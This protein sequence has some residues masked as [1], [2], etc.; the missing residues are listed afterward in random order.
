MKY[1][2]LDEAVRGLYELTS[3][4]VEQL[5]ELLTQRC[6]PRTKYAVRLA[7]ENIQEQRTYGIYERVVKEPKTGR[8]QY[9]AGQSYPE[10]IRTVR[11]LLRGW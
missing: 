10:E 3:F 11:S 4:D 8:W 7:L 2:T 9:V 6:N 5:M 1:E